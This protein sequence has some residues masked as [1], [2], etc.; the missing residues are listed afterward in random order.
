M[1]S[2]PDIFL[3]IGQSNMAGRGI[4]GE[5]PALRHPQ[6]L[7]FRDNLW[8]LAVEPLHTDKPQIA[9][10]GLG[11]SFAME[12]LAHAKDAQIGL[13]PCAV[14][15]TP[16]ARWMPGADLY[17]NAVSAAKRALTS[18]IL[19]GIL[20]HQ[21]EGDSGDPERAG[22]Y[23]ER[24]KQMVLG[25]RAALSAPRVPV[26]AGELGGFLRE[27]AGCAHFKTVNQQLRALTKVLPVYGCVSARG[28]TDKG[29]QLHFN[30][31]SLRTFGVRYARKWLEITGGK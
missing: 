14:G 28:L 20:W 17:E 18:G 30:S 9:G 1:K 15:G 21:G 22:S 12:L 13:V 16:L 7:M 10:V 4:L 31:Q 8:Q 26:V 11:M 24:F 25:L 3:L 19:R 29:D 23:G 5:V 6:I 27:H 2:K